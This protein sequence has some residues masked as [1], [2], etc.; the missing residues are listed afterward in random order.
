MTI[1]WRWIEAI[2]GFANVPLLIL[3]LL[4]FKETRGEVY[5]GKRAK[6]I[7]EK[8]GDKRYVCAIDL[9][10]RNVKDLMKAASVKAIHMLATELVVFAFGLWIAFAWF[11]TFLFLSVIPISKCSSGQLHASTD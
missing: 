6:I 4:T 7:R 2:Q 5:L 10:A 8:T 9:D 3:I 11:I 1:G